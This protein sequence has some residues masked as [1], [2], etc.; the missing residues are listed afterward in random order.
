MQIYWFVHKFSNKYSL[1]FI[2]D[3]SG[4]EMPA[5]VLFNL[6]SESSE[7]ENGK[8]AFAIFVSDSDHRPVSGS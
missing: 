2:K 3:V 4:A 8:V 1:I 5:N 7:S 6:L